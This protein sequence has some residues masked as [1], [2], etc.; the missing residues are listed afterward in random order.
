MVMLTAL[1]MPWAARLPSRESE[2]TR[3]LSPNSKHREMFRLR[4]LLEFP[5]STVER[6]AQRRLA[7]EQ[8]FVLPPSLHQP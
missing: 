1:S 7:N 6:V 4:E 2:Y 5:A 3:K 8:E